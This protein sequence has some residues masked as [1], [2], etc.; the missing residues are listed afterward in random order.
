[1]DEE[2]ALKIVQK[3]GL[4]LENLPDHFKKNKEIVLEAVK[5]EGM[6]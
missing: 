1:M 4:E 2:R 3:D 6:P 5:Q